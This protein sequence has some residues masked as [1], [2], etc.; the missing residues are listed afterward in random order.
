MFGKGT[1]AFTGGGAEI[2]DENKFWLHLML[3]CS[4]PSVQHLVIFRDI[5]SSQGWTVGTR[6]P[7]REMGTNDVVPAPGNE[8]K[9]AICTGGLPGV[10]A[11][12]PEVIACCVGGSFE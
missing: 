6:I 5:L 12:W 10:M 11:G 9:P 2:R 1:T 8:C 3:L 7:Q 4:Q